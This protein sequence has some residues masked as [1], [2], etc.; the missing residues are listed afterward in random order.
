MKKLLFTASLLLALS[1]NANA[2]NDVKVDLN[3]KLNTKTEKI[4]KEEIEECFLVE[5]TTVV[6]TVENPNQNEAE[7]SEITFTTKREYWIVC[8]E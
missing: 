4:S 2:N 3:K 6:V 5:V 1:F 7:L 8:V